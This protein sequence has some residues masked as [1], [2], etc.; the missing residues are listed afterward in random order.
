MLFAFVLLATAS[1]LSE[2]AK[3]S[4]TI[5]LS[6]GITDVPL[7]ETS[8]KEASSST[9][10]FD[11]STLISSSSASCF[12][13][14]GW[15]YVVTRAFHS[16]GTVDSNACPSLTAAKSAGVGTR[17]VY[18]FPCPT[19]SASASAQMSTMLQSLSSCSAWS[20]RV[21][22][23]IE[24]TQYWTGSSSNNKNFYQ[25]LVQAC[26]SQAHACGIYSSAYQW[27]SLFGSTSY[28]YGSDLPMWYA[29]YDG[30]PS[31]SDY[32]NYSYGGWTSP[33]AKQYAGTT[34]VCSMGIDKNYSPSF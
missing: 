34:T 27:S 4:D 28:S 26:K 13:S 16:S 1:A 14:N 25:S 12:N 30:N 24:G 20:G 5:G 6:A 23:D 9:K 32:P 2:V 22:L 18:M 8:S 29:H 31:F 17:D 7:N 33:H 11:V 15:S 21:W 10:G 3:R 19:C